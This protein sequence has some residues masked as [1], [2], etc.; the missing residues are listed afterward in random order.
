MHKHQL[1]SS[2][3]R[4]CDTLATVVPIITK[5][6]STITIYHMICMGKDKLKLTKAGVLEDFPRPWGENLVA[7]ALV[8]N[9]LHDFQLATNRI[10]SIWGFNISGVGI[11]QVGHLRNLSQA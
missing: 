4:E 8:T 5:I 11:Q 9:F 2:A 6:L 1:F 3:S 7:I 10:T